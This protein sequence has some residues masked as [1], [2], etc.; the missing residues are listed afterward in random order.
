MNS[1]N[2]HRVTLTIAERELMLREAVLSRCVFFCVVGNQAKGGTNSRATLDGNTI[3]DA[4]KKTN[5]DN[6]LQI[7]F[8]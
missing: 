5:T 8:P 3:S 6:S 7:L 4:V 2:K 1:P